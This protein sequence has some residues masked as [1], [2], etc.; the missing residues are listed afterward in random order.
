MWRR[1]PGMTPIAKDCFIS[2]ISHDI[3][4]DGWVTVWGLRDASKYGSR[5]TLD[6]PTLGQLDS[7]SLAF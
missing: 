3:S 2:S 1:P 7:N 5:L 6:N 4:V